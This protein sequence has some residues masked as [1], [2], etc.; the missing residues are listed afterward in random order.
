MFYDV[1]T[2]Y[3]FKAIILGFLISCLLKPFLSLLLF[4]PQEGN[5]EALHFDAHVLEVQRKQHDIRGCRCVFHVEYDHDGSQ[6]FQQQTNLGQAKVI[7]EC[8]DCSWFRNINM[9]WFWRNLSFPDGRRWWAWK[10]CPGDQSTREIWFR[11]LFISDANSAMWCAS[12]WNY[13]ERE[14]LHARWS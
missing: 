14:I 3:S 4:E 2:C 13:P 8:F 9:V 10:D 6:V 1:A 5:D 7:I 11:L 12:V